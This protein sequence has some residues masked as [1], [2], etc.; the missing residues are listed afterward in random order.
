MVIDAAPISRRVVKPSDCVLAFGIPTTRAG[1]RAAEESANADFAKRFLGGWAQYHAQFVIDLETVEPL[2]R[3]WGVTVLHEATLGDFARALEG[4]F[5]VA[6]LFSHWHE[7][8]VEFRDGL[9]S[10]SAIM[11]AVPAAYSG[12]LD[13][14]VC[15]P[16]TL[17]KELR[18]HRG[19][20]IVK[21]LA[22]E[23]APHYWLYFYR[24]LFS[25]L[26]SRSLTYL[27]A[28]EEVACAFLD[29]ALAKRGGNRC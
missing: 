15:H 29:S 20:C 10:T 6:I 4:P 3:N 21:Y 2:L 12:I 17:V 28:I 8:A 19:N 7:D 24:T 5:D 16:L 13:L 27:G 18:M 25:Q 9:E 1:F 23:A 26:N 11:S 22:T 14:C